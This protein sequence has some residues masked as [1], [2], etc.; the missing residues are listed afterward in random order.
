LAR[1]DDGEQ[2]VGHRLG[3]GGG[4]GVAGQGGAG[5]EQ[6]ALRGQDRRLEGGHRPGGV[7][8]GDEHPPGAQRVHGG[9]EGV[10][11]DAVVD[12]VHASAAGELAHGCGDVDALVPVGDDVVVAVGQ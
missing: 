5:D 3:G 4:V 11:T 7:A 9:G 12:D 2:V 8:V 10:G 6:R 1:R